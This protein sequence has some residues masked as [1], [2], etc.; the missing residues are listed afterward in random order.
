MKALGGS[1][2][3]IIEI[4]SEP[5]TG[6]EP[7]NQDGKAENGGSGMSRDIDVEV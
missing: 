6:V 1:Q 5:E 7:Q 4:A 2:K 3:C